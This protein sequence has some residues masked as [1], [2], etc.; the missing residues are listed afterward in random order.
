MVSKTQIRGD[1]KK[2]YKGQEILER[3]VRPL[4]E[5]NTASEV[6]EIQLF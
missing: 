5:R 1:N 2:H 3:H 4:H 6:E